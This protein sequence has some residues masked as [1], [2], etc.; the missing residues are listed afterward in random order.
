MTA[1]ANIPKQVQDAEE[2]IARASSHVA[3]KAASMAGDV[4]AKIDQTLERADAAL[5]TVSEQTREVAEQAKT[6]GENLK[7]AVE[8][9]IK[10]QPITALLVAL[11]GGFLIG[12]MWRG[13][14]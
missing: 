7:G 9:T 12:A 2:A 5:T 11:A 14:S 6:A 1:T 3:A 10:E 4:G 13:R 8:D